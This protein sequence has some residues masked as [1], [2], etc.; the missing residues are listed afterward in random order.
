MCLLNVLGKTSMYEVCLIYIVS[1][2]VLFQEAQLR[3]KMPQ[4]RKL[5]DKRGRE[6]RAKEM[7]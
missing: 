2:A 4:R 1:N 7:W 5:N 3:R 6:L